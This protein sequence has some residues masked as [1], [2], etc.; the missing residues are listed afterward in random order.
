MREVDI[1]S[2]RI[3]LI[4]GDIT[5]QKADA[6]V[7][8]ANSYLKHGGGVAAA[9]VRTGGDIIQDESD[10]LGYVPVGS[11]AVTGAG[12]LPVKYVIHAVGPRMGEGDEDK[13]LLSATNAVLEKVKELNLRSVAFPAISTGIFGY[14]VERCA[15]IMLNG[16]VD[17]LKTHDIDLSIIF[18]L[19]NDSD[20]RV[21]EKHL[22]QI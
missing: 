4:K 6:I 18:C 10:K 2:G 3:R 17:F 14:P 7:N 19:W 11:C 13:K 9:I 8:A 5:E 20:Y 12:R 21:F 1:A 16:S 15:R 22:E